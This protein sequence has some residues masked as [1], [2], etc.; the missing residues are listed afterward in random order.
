MNVDEVQDRIVL[1]EIKSGHANALLD[2]MKDNK[3]VMLNGRV[4]PE[5]DNYTSVSA[6][7]SA[8]VDYIMTAQTSVNQ[9]KQ[10][11]VELTT[12][13]IQQFH[14]QT[15]LGENCKAPDHSLLHAT[16][17][18][19]SINEYS[20]QTTE[21]IDQEVNDNSK[22]KK[23]DYKN[24]P[25]NFLKSQNWQSECVDLI[26]NLLQMRLNQNSI[27]EYYDKLCEKLFVEIDANINYKWVYTER[28]R[29]KL[30]ISKPYWD[31][32]LT[33]LWKNMVRAEKCYIKGISNEGLNNQ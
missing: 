21:P 22:F 29:K 18:L 17:E 27:D 2:F 32:E 25:D 15:L 26:D 14:L 13:L 4:T 10:M 7:G 1:D 30:K 19:S 28:S 33:I 31:E 5:F 20:E 23:Y 9:C 16:F 8:V 3:M 12:D 11:K 24:M 6:R